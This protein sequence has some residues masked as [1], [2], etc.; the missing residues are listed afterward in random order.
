MGRLQ[1]VSD[2]C[3]IIIRVIGEK[4]FI[5]EDI[6]C[7]KGVAVKTEKNAKYMPLYAQLTYAYVRTLIIMFVG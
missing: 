7:M 3:V 1:D 5:L 2:G 4:H 6:A